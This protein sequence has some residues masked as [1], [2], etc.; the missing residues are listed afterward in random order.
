MQAQFAGK[1]LLNAS[2]ALRPSA[3]VAITSPFP[4]SDLCTGQRSAK[5]PQS[6]SPTGLLLRF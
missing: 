5:I 6:D 4:A 1:V 3:F 2:S